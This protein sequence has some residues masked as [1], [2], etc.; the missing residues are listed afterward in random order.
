MAA[1]ETAGIQGWTAAVFPVAPAASRHQD[2][3]DRLTARS[4]PSS[5]TCSSNTGFRLTPAKVGPPQDLR[6][7]AG[8]EAQVRGRRRGETVD[9]RDCGCRRLLPRS[10]SRQLDKRTQP[11]ERCWRRRRT[12]SPP[13]ECP[14]HVGHPSIPSRGYA[15]PRS[16][17]GVPGLVAN[18]PLTVDSK[19]RWLPRGLPNG[20]RIPRS[21]KNFHLALTVAD[22]LVE[23]VERFG[24]R[25]LGR[26]LRP[27]IDPLAPP[28][29]RP[30]TSVNRPSRSSSLRRPRAHHDAPS[31]RSR[32]LHGCST[33]LAR[34]EMSTLAFS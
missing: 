28:S 3:H 27:M 11:I 22:D 24:A 13:R 6:G 7:Q 21:S 9:G 29:R 2:H 23:H 26:W 10:A 34:V 25:A 20:R 33:R 4:M 17:G 31:R 14:A 12:E 19:G 1:S 16:G 30:R 32:Q 15:L 18:L 5:A 8:G